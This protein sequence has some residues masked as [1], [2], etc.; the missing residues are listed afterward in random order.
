MRDQV[1]Y[2]AT[3]LSVHL[4][5]L[6]LMLGLT[7][8]AVKH[9]PP[10]SIDFTLN[11]CPI[12]E[13][14]PEKLTKPAVIPRQPAA[15]KP[16]PPVQQVQAPP[17]QAPPPVPVAAQYADPTPTAPAVGKPVADPVPRAVV[18]PPPPVLTPAAAAPPGVSSGGEAKMNPEK[19]KQKYLKEHFAYIRDLIVTRL[20][21]PQVARRM[22]WSGRVVVMFVV[23]EDGSVRSLRIKESSGYPVLDN[24]AMETVK[25]VAPFPRPPVAA[26]LVMPV[27]FTLE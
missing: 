26:E 14:P 23:A 22:G 24:S 6:V 1:K 7:A 15:V 8:Q 12:P 3:S 5:L 19:A 21:Y 11:S 4:G 18:A 2:Y 25:K 20:T 9:T 16:P 13:V 27:Q 17:E 10:I